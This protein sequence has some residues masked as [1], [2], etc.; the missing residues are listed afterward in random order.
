MVGAGA[1][2][3]VAVLL[4]AALPVAAAGIGTAVLL[5]PVLA[6]L[7]DR[8]A[9]DRELAHRAQQTR[10]FAAYLQAVDELAANGVDGTERRRLRTLDT[11]AARESVRSAGATGLAA[12]LAVVALGAAALGS[13]TV[14]APQVSAGTVPA[15]VVAV[16]VLLPLAL[17]DPALAA[18]A[19]LQQ[20]P[21]LVGALRRLAP[22]LH[23]AAVQRPPGAQPV[24]SVARL[25]L[26]SAT[27]RW[28]GADQPAVRAVTA[29]LDKGEWLGVTGPS[30]S[31]KSTLLSVLLGWLPLEEGRYLVDGV[32]ARQLDVRQLR[33]RIAWC[34]QE[35][36]LFAS[37]L[38]GNL[39]LAR[40]RA[41]P[42]T[43]NELWAV[44]R[45]VGLA[46]LVAAL[47]AGFDTPIGS[48]G[49]RLSG[50]ER[51]R[52]AVARTLLSG[53]DVVLL[54]EP[55]AHLDAETA[56]QLMADLRVAL[57][58]TAVVLVS[59]RNADHERTDAV[60]ALADSSPAPAR[61]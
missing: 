23:A 42:P 59:H 4:P 27:V 48:E 29:R 26:E 45:L 11:V 38:R 58:Q 5:A 61:V 13:A 1:L 31:G 44:L 53:A 22:T 9:R 47:P 18:I 35:G 14:A 8:R 7:T 30:G 2:L 51:Q 40:S 56:A 25:Q 55:T 16:L 43:E 57:V 60:L 39:A 3:P 34:P 49:A 33:R 32:D 17:L 6:L 21:A 50:G 41:D 15:A 24:P 12:A 37:T 46:D 10:R 54:D 19:A 20:A 36:H 28:P 52:L